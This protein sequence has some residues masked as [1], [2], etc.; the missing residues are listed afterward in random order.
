M[1]NPDSDLTQP[2]LQ[3]GR[4]VFGGRYLLQELLGVGGMGSVWRAREVSLRRE[5]AL[6]FLPL[7]LTRDEPAREDLKKE[8]LVSQELTHPHIIRVHSFEEDAVLAAISMEL[9]DGKPLNR[10]KAERPNSL[11]SISELTPWV[12]QLCAAL[13]YAHRLE[14]IH[15]DLKPGNIMISAK[16]QVKVVDFGIAASISEATTRTVPQ[17]SFGHGGTLAYMSPQQARGEKPTAADDLYS[18]G[19]T[20]YDCLTGKPPFFRGEVYAQVL[21]TAPLPLNHR[22]AEIDPHAPRIP[23]HWEETILACLAKKREDRPASADAIAALLIRDD[24]T[25][26]M[27]SLP[28]PLPPSPTST[29]VNQERVLPPRPAAPV[30]P[31]PPPVREPP[32]AAAVTSDRATPRERA[33]I[34]LSTRVDI[35]RKTFG[36][37]GS[38][39]RR[40]TGVLGTVILLGFIEGWILD[41]SG[42]FGYGGWLHRSGWF[43]K[44]IDDWGRHVFSFWNLEKTALTLFALFLAVQIGLIFALTRII[45][46]G[47]VAITSQPEGA[48]VQTSYGKKL[49]RTPLLLRL[50]IPGRY[51]FRL[52]LDRAQPIEL[53]GVLEKNQILRLTTTFSS[54]Q[55]S[56]SADRT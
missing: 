32:P 28:P 27:P 18:L 14:I 44:T 40:M 55:K 12:S 39:K 38:L 8:V 41:S 2:L 21:E 33:A 49:G 37:D 19:A 35:Y 11:F 4:P 17:S 7:S 30:P 54:A 10:L 23:H 15:R 26:R 13:A 50:M 48:L 36:L 29:T 46:F 47:R 43:F 53:S 31:A 51:R 3:P 16:G 42:A 1:H 20:L 24:S 52:T 22:R 45:G 9:V 56:A 25:E 34:A 6:K 5:V